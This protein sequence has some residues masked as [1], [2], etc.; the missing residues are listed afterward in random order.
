MGGTI[1][2]TEH[3]GMIIFEDSTTGESLSRMVTED[4][5]LKSSTRN[6]TL[7][8][9]GEVLAFEDGSGYFIHEGITPNRTLVTSQ[10]PGVRGAESN[11][12]YPSRQT[13][14]ISIAAN[15]TTVTGS[16]VTQ[17]TSELVVGDVIQTSDEN[18]ILEESEDTLILETLEII[19]HEDVT[20]AGVQNH[21]LNG[22]EAIIIQTFKWYIAKEDSTHSAHAYTPN[23][24]GSY[25]INRDIEQYNILDESTDSGLYLALEDDSGVLRIE[26]SEFSTGVA[27]LLETGDK[28]VHTEKGEFKI[29]TITDDD[30]L[31]VTRKHWEGTDFVPYWKQTTE[32][33]TTAVVAYK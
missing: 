33:E 21:V 12:M 17:F 18:V 13:G 24:L 30:T 15:S 28:M 11:Y 29:A 4:D 20:I 2:V 27:L 3:R 22:I 26:L 9:L 10:V 16:S 7:D 6:V 8:L 1:H 5:R 32:Y 19:A 23:V 25:T 14:S 31:T